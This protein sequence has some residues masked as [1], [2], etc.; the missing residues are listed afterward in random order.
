MENNV[1]ILSAI[2]I[3]IYSRKT[4]WYRILLIRKPLIAIKQQLTFFKQNNFAQIVMI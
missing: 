1:K 4:Y 3:I 2:N